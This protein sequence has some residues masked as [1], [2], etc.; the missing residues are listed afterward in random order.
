MF[1]NVI[2]LLCEQQVLETINDER[3]AKKIRIWIRSLLDKMNTLVEVTA[4]F[5]KELARKN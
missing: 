5:L 3:K 4:L 2:R 1:N